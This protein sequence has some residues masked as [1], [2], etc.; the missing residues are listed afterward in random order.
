MEAFEAKKRD[1]FTF[2]NTNAINRELR[3]LNAWFAFFSGEG[4]LA[5]THAVAVATLC[6]SESRFHV[7]LSG[8]QSTVGLKKDLCRIELDRA[9]NSFG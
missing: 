1:L 8:F 9:G 4:V 7:R 2:G 6:D 3:L 5:I